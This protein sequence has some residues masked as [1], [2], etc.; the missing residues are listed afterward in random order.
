MYAK[1]GIRI[2]YNKKKGHNTMLRKETIPRDPNMLLSFINTKLRD[3]YASLSDLCE[4]M[5]LESSDIEHILSTLD[6]QYDQKLNR[7]L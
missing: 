1:I 3:Q 4:D 7:F 6:Y 2:L 5:D